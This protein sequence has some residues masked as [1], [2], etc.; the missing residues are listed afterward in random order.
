MIRPKKFQEMV[1]HG[2]LSRAYLQNLSEVS[3]LKT[4]EGK[5]RIRKV[6]GLVRKK[7]KKNAKQST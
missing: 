7:K 6:E 2:S 3:L 5:K 1:L 4:S